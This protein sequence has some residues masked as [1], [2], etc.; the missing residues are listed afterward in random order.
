MRITFASFSNLGARAENQDRLLLPKF[1][2]GSF[3]VAAIADGVGGAKGGADAASIAT[4]LASKIAGPN[5]KLS[6]F[7]A[8]IP[9]QFQKRVIEDD[10]LAK[11]STTLSVVIIEDHKLLIGH[12]GDT[13]IYHLRGRG[14]NTLTR[15]Q[16]EIAEL[17]RRGIINTRQAKR[18][19]RRN[20][21]LSA[22]S[23]DGN[24]EVQ[25][26][27]ADLSIGDR[28]VMLTDGV[29]Q[30]VTRGV[31]VALSLANENVVDFVSALEHAA[32]E[33][34]PSDNFSALA[35]EVSD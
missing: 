21:L 12:V 27:E 8:S 5:V 3:F 11:M 6:E 20:V 30:R 32:I 31:I 15:D 22:L 16:T 34:E 33:R 9:H 7:F 29:H 14:L 10:Q 19:P 18:Y 4:D 1:K 13:R 23:V 25:E 17:V 24:Y 2:E 26:S 35:I 28:I